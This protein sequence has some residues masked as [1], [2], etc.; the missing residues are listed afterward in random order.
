M[1]V[2][3]NILVIDDDEGICKTLSLILN[4]KGFKTETVKTGQEAIDKTRKK[5]FD[6]TLI[7]VNLPDIEGINLI[8]LI[9]E[10]NPYVEIMMITAY[11]TVETAIQALGQVETHRRQPLQRSAFMMILPAI[12]ELYRLLL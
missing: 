11:A 4:K 7:D 1:L 10:I 12:Y 2:E 9:K 5:F 8:R 6:I 3:E